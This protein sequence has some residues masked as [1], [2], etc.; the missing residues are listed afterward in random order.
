MNLR[1]HVKHFRAHAAQCGVLQ[2]EHGRL[3]IQKVSFQATSSQAKITLRQMKHR[4]FHRGPLRDIRVAQ[5]VVELFPKE[6]YFQS[7]EIL[8]QQ[9]HVKIW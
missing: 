5:L 9:F 4:I 7:K 8:S 6:Y 2:A 1:S 3:L